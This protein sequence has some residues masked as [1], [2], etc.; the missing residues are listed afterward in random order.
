VTSRSDTSRLAGQGRDGRGY[1]WPDGCVRL[2]PVGFKV[3]DGPC[4]LGT[5]G[6]VLLCCFRGH[7]SR[8]SPKGCG[9]PVTLAGVSRVS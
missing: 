4:V 2:A 3:V 5:E 1:P 6:P 8:H 9:G 7:W